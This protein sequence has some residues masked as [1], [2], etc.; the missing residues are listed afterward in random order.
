MGFFDDV[1]RNDTK[2]KPVDQRPSASQQSA[3]DK[4][5]TQG[6]LV[7]S[8]RDFL[9]SATGGGQT[10]I[11]GAKHV[12][13]YLSQLGGAVGSIPGRLGEDIGEFGADVH[14]G[15][16]GVEVPRE[17]VSDPRPSAPSPEFIERMS[18]ELADRGFQTIEDLNALEQENLTPEGQQQ[19]ARLR[20]QLEVQLA[21][22]SQE[23]AT[24]NARG[25]ELQRQAVRMTTEAFP[26]GAYS[27]CRF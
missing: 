13:P 17:E 4:R 5:Q 12:G 8:L 25:Q 16:F 3:A 18:L 21:Q 20:Q 24:L 23:L 26:R 10:D 14:R 19:L 7:N 15:L 11:L 27:W 1:N 6:G 22:Q 2:R 9:V